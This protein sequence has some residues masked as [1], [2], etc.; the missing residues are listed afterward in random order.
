MEVIQPL[1][2]N[3]TVWGFAL[4]SLVPSWS[5]LVFLFLVLFMFVKLWQ[6]YKSYKK[7]KRRQEIDERCNISSNQE[8]IFVSIASYRDPECSRTLFDLFEKAHCPFRIFVG[9]CQQNLASVDQDAL[10]GYR[11]LVTN[12]GI[13]DFSAQ[14]RM[15]S[16]DADEAKG[17]MY[18]RHLIETKLY[19]GE[20]FYLVTDSHMLFTP[21]WDKNLLSE[22]WQCRGRSSKPILT[23]YPEDFQPMH[24][25]IPPY[26]YDQAVGSYLRFK[27]FHPQNQMIEI[28]GPAFARQPTA[29]VLG[30]FWGGCMSFG[31]GS[32]IEEVPFD[33]HCPFVFIGEEISMAVR[34]WTN[35]YD[36]YHP[37]RMY[38]YHMWTR[39]RPVFWE[40]FS[41]KRRIDHQRRQEQEQESY[42]RLNKLLRINHRDHPDQAVSLI[43]PYGLGQ[44]RSL[45]DYETFIGL[46]MDKKTI[47]S[48]NGIMGVPPQA[49][50]TDILCRFG[51]WNQF[52]QT[53]NV[54]I[55]ALGGQFQ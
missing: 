49:D 44:T 35:G 54:L 16:I 50:A 41:D 48:L 23:C 6:W 14:I 53:K 25:T 33:F 3:P 11:S 17:P 52:K 13:G 37:T 27:R 24:R 12:D 29:P 45:S 5:G 9:V 21:D 15:L 47:L 7:Q 4:G 2:Q 46:N 26:R 36:F 39:N 10:Q 8:T 31:P 19:R 38:M 32:M 55:K 28:E 1:A 22:W 20:Q 18:A 30:M 51:T 34:L 43:P 42:Q 40:I